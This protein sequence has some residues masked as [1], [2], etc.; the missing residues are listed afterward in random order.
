MLQIQKAAVL[1]EF[2]RAAEGAGTV[3]DTAAQ[4]VK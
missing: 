4:T 3:A 1:S 2:H